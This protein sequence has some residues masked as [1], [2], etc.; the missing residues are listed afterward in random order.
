M[1]AALRRP[2][3]SFAKSKTSPSEVTSAV[4]LRSMLV[5][6]ITGFSITRRYASTG[7][8]GFASRP[9]TPRST[10]TLITRAPSGK[11]MPRKKISDHAECVRS[12]RTGVVSRRMGKVPFSDVSSSSLPETVADDPRDAPCGTSSDSHRPISRWSA[13]DQQA[14]GRQ[15]NG[16]RRPAKS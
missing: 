6:R 16:R 4:A 15:G 8:L 13:P 9:W 11:S 1:T 12:M 7:G 3:W 10:D 14:S 2:R 5:S